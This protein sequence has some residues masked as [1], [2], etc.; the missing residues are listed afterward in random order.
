MTKLM[1][2]VK[3]LNLYSECRKSLL[4][5]QIEGKNGPEK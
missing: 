3:H 2:Y 1:M 5:G 4:N